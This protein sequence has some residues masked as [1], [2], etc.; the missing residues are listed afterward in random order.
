LK[1]KKKF[2]KDKRANGSDFFVNVFDDSNRNKKFTLKIWTIYLLEN[3]VIC[4][5]MKI[6]ISEK[7]KFKLKS[8]SVERTSYRKSSG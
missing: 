7:E 2:Q 6:E 1:W 4:H 5:R 8:E 3:D